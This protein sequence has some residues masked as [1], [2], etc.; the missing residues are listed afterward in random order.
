LNRSPW[1]SVLLLYVR[2]LSHFYLKT[3]T[4]K[5]AQLASAFTAVTLLLGMGTLSQMTSAQTVQSQINRER[6]P[7][8]RAALRALETARYHLQKGARDFGG[9]RVEALRDTNKAIEEVQQAIAE[10]RD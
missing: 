5:I 4:L 9:K 7:E 8:L 1:N 6:H 3:V 10:D 2:L